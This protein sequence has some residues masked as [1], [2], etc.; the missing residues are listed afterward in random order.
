MVEQMNLARQVV[1]QEIDQRKCWLSDPKTERQHLFQP[2]VHILAHFSLFLLLFQ[3]LRFSSSPQTA[4]LYM[5]PK[6]RPKISLT[7]YTPM[8]YFAD[9]LE[10]IIFAFNDFGC[11]KKE[12]IYLIGF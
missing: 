5:V 3:Q 1:G 7:R 9:G 12:K 8:A 4:V 10:A 6:N 2:S 11:S